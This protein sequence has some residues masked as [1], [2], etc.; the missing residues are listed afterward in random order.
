[1][2]DDLLESLKTPLGAFETNVLLAG[3]EGCVAAWA[4]CRVI[5]GFSPFDLPPLTWEPSLA[6]WALV[7][8]VVIVLV[9]LAVEGLSGVLER[10][11]T[12]TSFNS[13]KLRPAFTNLFGETT[14][15][16]W[17]LAQ[18]WI[19]KSSEASSEFA[20]RRLRLLTARNTTFVLFL[21]TVSVA[22]G[23]LIQHPSGWRRTLL[24]VL[25]GGTFSWV[26]FA[27]VWIA[28]QQGYTRA[29]QDAGRAG[30]L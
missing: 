13:H 19:W 4:G 1:M 12:W 2:S 23:L 26:L 9:G 7:A 17:R 11:V 30:E 29:I 15:S 5:R 14:D 6:I 8:I 24:I 21:T 10:L 28:A 27:W 16:D 22:V 18:R 20:R 3:I 25:N